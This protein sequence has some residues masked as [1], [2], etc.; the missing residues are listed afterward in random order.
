MT[1]LD[2]ITALA[3][4][5]NEDPELW[6]NFGETTK[7]DVYMK[8]VSLDIINK[9]KLGIPII[10]S[11]KE[12]EKMQKASTDLAEKTVELE[13]LAEERKDSPMYEVIV[14]MLTHLAETSASWN[15]CLEMIPNI[16]HIV[17]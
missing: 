17:N 14:S 11:K 10:I 9:I 12:Y 3:I 7:I 1:S 13:T 5:T 2:F 8:E 15:H 6:N 4:V 16:A